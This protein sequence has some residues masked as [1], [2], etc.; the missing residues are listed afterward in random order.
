M[1]GTLITHLLHENDDTKV[2]GNDDYRFWDATYFPFHVMLSKHKDG[3][4][5]WELWLVGAGMWFRGGRNPIWSVAIQE[6]ADA[7]RA[8][9]AQ[10][11]EQLA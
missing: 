5:E 9:L 10:L 8:A 1:A 7:R 6:I 4:F 3:E 2:Y 11:K